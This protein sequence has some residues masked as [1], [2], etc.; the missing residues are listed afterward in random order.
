MGNRYLPLASIAMILLATIDGNSISRAAESQRP[1]SAADYETLQAAV[2]ANP[3]RAI[4][5]PDGDFQLER[6]LRITADHTELFGSG[7]LI[8]TN[9]DCSI[10]RVE[11]AAFVRLSGLTL[12]RPSDRLETSQE[13][14][15]VIDGR[16]VEIDAVRVLDNRGPAGSIRMT[17][18]RDCTIRDCLVY[19][20]MFVTVEDRTSNPSS[21]IAF[22]AIDGTGI[23]IVNC[24]GALLSGNRV[25]DENTIP[26]KEFQA[27]HDLGRIVERASQRGPDIDPVTWERGVVGGNW[28]QG[29]GIYVSGDRIRLLGNYIRNAAR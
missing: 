4:H 18:S 17:G 2:D 29:S 24:I 12:T 10:I 22:R 1:I 21:G 11:G 20:Y 5:V 25:V 13:G 27:K 9:P 23:V 7:R 28:H 15:T 16:F 8:Q 3:G 26:T 19:N 6:E 14:I